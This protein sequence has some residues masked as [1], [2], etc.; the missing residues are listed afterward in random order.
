[1][2]STSFPQAALRLPEV[3]HCDVPAALPSPGAS[4]YY[5]LFLRLRYACQRK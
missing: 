5:F 1:M 2:R 4:I 3:S